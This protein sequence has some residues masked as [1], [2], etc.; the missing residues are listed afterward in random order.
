MDDGSYSLILVV[1][2]CTK[3]PNS[4]SS[5]FTPMSSQLK[6]PNMG[7][8]EFAHALNTTINRSTPPI[9]FL[10]TFKQVTNWK[11]ASFLKSNIEF[12]HLQQL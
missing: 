12:I 8:L 1:G 9:M 4:I 2:P 3:F 6:A 7:S 5:Y 10:K 11:S